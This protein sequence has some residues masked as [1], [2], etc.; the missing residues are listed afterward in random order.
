MPRQVWLSNDGRFFETEVEAI[1]DDISEE[2]AA[3]LK[4]LLICTED[5]DEAINILEN[6][7][8][9]RDILTEYINRLEI[10]K[11]TGK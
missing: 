3:R 5:Y 11:V 8:V 10:L 1:E 9:V 7:T 4:S 6:A 2:T